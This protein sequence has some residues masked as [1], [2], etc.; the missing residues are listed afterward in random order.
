MF[1]LFRE[2]VRIALDS[3]KTQLLHHLDHYYHR[4][5][6]MGWWAS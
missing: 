3:I 5:W 2:N 4:D 6:N 1:G